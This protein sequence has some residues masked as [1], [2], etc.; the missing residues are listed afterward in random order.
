MEGLW[1]NWEK[2]TDKVR[3]LLCRKAFKSSPKAS[4]GPETVNLLKD[5]GPFPT[6]ISCSALQYL[7]TH[8][9]DK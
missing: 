9:F 1:L 6:L 7:T 2:V 8:T 4:S 5:E 3:E